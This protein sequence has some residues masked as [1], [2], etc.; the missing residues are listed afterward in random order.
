MQVMTSKLLTLNLSV[1]IIFFA[2]YVL[3]IKSNKIN[4]T[5]KCDVI[6]KEINKNI[7]LPF[8]TIPCWL[9]NKIDVF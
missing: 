6:G 3:E 5:F 4:I 7:S 2:R 8:I 1:L 9:M